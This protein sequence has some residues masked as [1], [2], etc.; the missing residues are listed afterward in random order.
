[1]KLKLFKQSGQTLVIIAIA[2]IAL[3]GVVGLAVDGSAKFSDRR[4]AQNAAD[5]AALSA[6]LVKANGLAAGK[7]ETVCSTASGYTNSAFCLDIIDAAWDRAEENGYKGLLPDSVDVYSPPISG[8][9][10]NQSSYV[11]VIITSYVDTYLARVVGVRR[12][13]NT[14]EAVSYLYKGG[15]LFGGASLISVNPSPGCPTSGGVPGGGSVDIGGNGTVNLDGGGIFVN[16]DETCGYV[17]TSC[18]L[19]L[20]I[21]NGGKILTAGSPVYMKDKTNGAD[22]NTSNPPAIDITQKQY[23][24]P[25]DI[26]MPAEPVEC[27]QTAYAY[28]LGGDKWRITPGYYT[29]FPHQE[30]NGGHG[31]KKVDIV[32]D[33]GVYCVDG[34]VEWNGNIFNSLDGTSGVTIYI[35]SGNSFSFRIDSDIELYADGSPDYDNFLIIVNGSPSNI[36]SC[37]INGGDYLS[38]NGMIY[39][40]YCD[41]TINGNSTSL[42]DFHAQ[43]LGWNLK[44]DGGST[45]NFKYDPNYVPVLKR[46]VGLMR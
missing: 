41:V 45:I 5:T 13:K 18:G 27:S 30:I 34:D 35:K 16:S 44:V 4:H 6:A 11:Q 7:T 36:E 32:M 24:I 33:H 12:T 14:V 46:R 42:S 43:V 20:N 22:C 3:V 25:D 10:Y 26:Y 28:D 31:G 40:P 38:M 39:A 19:T 23:V 17:Q 29:I 9:Y 37:E 21:T 8:P 2:A 15:P 1:M